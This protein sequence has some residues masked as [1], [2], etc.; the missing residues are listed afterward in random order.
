MA[1][2]EK[3]EYKFPDE[4]EKDSK[5]AESKLEIEIEDDTPEEDK[6]KSPLP[7]KVREELYNDELED[8]SSKVKKKLLALK[9]LAHDERREKE[10]ALR[11]QNEAISVAQR[12]VEE[13]KKLKNSLS[14]TEKATVSTISKNLEFENEAAKRAYKE[15]YETGDTDKII[16]AQ[17]RITQL[18][19]Q[20]EKVKQFKPRQVEEEEYTAP[21]VQTDPTA[22]R[23]KSQNPWFGE[24]KLMTATALAMHELLKD[25]GV[26][27]ASDEYYRRIDKEMRH[28]FADRFEKD[29]RPTKSAVVA[30]ATRST[31][32]KTVRL[33]SSQLNIAKK[34]GLTPEQYA[35][36]VLQMEN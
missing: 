30:P 7:A 36:A 35:H 1:D 9:K 18:A 25:E 24:D 8:Y 34:L 21:R 10:Q 20:N 13:N 28:R 15:A 32:S 31:A 26:V 33:K 5:E 23:W 19:L 11:E 12:L 22:V 16:E 29:E 2:F 6:D 3:D 4:V 17:Q 14:E 27:L